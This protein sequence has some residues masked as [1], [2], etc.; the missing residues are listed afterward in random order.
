[1]DKNKIFIASITIIIAFVVFL[2]VIG[3]SV[4]VL[5]DSADIASEPNICSRTLGVN[6]ETLHYNYTNKHC[7]NDTN[8]SVITTNVLRQLPLN[9]LFSRSGIIL[10]I[11][12]AV[13]LIYAVGSLIY[14]KKND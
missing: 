10:L 11:F 5:K 12:F 1:M 9:A 4:D 8:V 3:D 2:K 6:G 13:L 7:D 14:E